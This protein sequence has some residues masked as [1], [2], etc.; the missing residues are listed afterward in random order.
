M[1]RF[2][3]SILVF[4]IFVLLLWVTKSNNPFFGEILIGFTIL[5]LLLI[6]YG[7]YEIQFN[8]FVKS[9]NN[10][11]TTKK[12]A[13]I[14]FDD[15][16]EPG[17]TEKILAILKNKNVKATFFCIGNKIENNNALFQSIHEE[18]H[19]IGN[20]SFS[21]QISFTFAGKNNVKKEIDST[22]QL[23]EAITNRRCIYFRPPFG[24]ANPNIA[25]AIAQSGMQSVGWNIRTLDTNEPALEKIIEKINRELNPG[26]ILLFHDTSKVTQAGLSVI[27][28]IIHAKGYT[29]LRIDELLNVK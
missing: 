8:F 25:T 5:F 28:D 7:C 4:I 2:H 24:V 18:G 27:I 26:S 9:I 20:H 21:H 11:S 29:L 19:L 3:F 6:A 10:I 23:I 15:G 12:V 14:T 22:N 17:A 1:S 16:P 13:A